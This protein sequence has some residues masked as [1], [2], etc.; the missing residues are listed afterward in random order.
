MVRLFLKI[1]NQIE[2]STFWTHLPTTPLKTVMRAHP[3]LSN[4]VLPD[5]EEDLP[6]YHRSRSTLHAQ[7][8]DDSNKLIQTSGNHQA[9]AVGG[10]QNV[11]GEFEWPEAGPSS[12][13]RTSSSRLGAKAAA[14]IT[15]AVVT[16]LLSE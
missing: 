4:P 14:A 15:G 13:G 12:S 9:T 6:I 8:P 3:D 1:L 11:N 16:S 7:F 5:A 10:G 2:T